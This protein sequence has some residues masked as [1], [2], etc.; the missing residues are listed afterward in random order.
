MSQKHNASNETKAS[1]T[2]VVRMRL[3]STVTTI[4]VVG[5]EQGGEGTSSAHDELPTGHVVTS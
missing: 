5:G 4:L 1:W 2:S 3:R